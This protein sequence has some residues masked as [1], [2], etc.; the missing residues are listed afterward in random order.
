MIP[1]QPRLPDATRLGAVHL[2]VADPARMADFYQ[3]AIGLSVTAGA[4]GSRLLG[5]GG[6]PLLVLHAS[7]GAS[8]PPRAA[9]L[10]HFCLAV[11]RRNA[12][13]WWLKR[14]LDGKFE[15]QGL[16]DHHMAEAIYLSDPEG[17]GIELNWDRPRDQWDK[18]A[19]LTQGNGPLDTEGLLNDLQRQPVV[20]LPKDTRVG[21]MHLH[22][23]DLAVSE[24]FY[25]GLLGLEKQFEVPGQA[26][27]TSAGGYHHHVAFNIWHGRNAAPVPEGSLGLRNLTLHIPGAGE[28]DKLKR[29]LEAASWPIQAEGAGFLIR[30]PSQNGIFCAP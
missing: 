9:G 22:V 3:A 7:P 20:A 18:E 30:D 28:L 4:E 14:L 10:Y 16:V 5:A 2:N 1:A 12:L 27:F 23:G 19:W 13:G 17:N 26:V 25:C 15:L 8:K 21:H 29:R 24:A 11:E 6:E